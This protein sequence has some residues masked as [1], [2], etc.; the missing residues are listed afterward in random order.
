[1]NISVLTPEKE[2]YSG[3]INSISV[4]GVEGK[5]QVLRN[6]APIVSALAEGGVTIKRADGQFITFTIERGF[7]EVLNNEIAL[8]VQGAENF[9]D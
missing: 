8:L 9:R 7:I 2:L 6:H 5:F 4:P 1:M 3:S